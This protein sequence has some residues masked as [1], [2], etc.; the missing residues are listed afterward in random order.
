MPQISVLMSCLFEAYPVDQ[1]FLFQLSG[2][3]GGAHLPTSLLYDGTDTETA[4]RFLTAIQTVISASAV[5]T[6]R[7]VISI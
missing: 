1:E 2:N 4:N 5:I 7:H 6:H 3:P